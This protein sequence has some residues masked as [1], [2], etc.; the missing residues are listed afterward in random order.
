LCVRT[1]VNTN[2][3]GYNMTRL[4]KFILL[5][6]FIT[7]SSCEQKNSYSKVDVNVA[8][9]SNKI[10]PLVNFLDNPDSCKKALLF[11][12]SATTI[13]NG[14]FLCYYNKLMFLYSLKQYDKAVVTVNECI[15]LN[16]SGQDLYLT[17]G[18]LYERVGDTVS[19][20]R[21]FQ[22]S[23]TICNSV[24]DTMSN[25]NT[26]YDILVGNKAISLIMLG[27]EVE[28]D[29]IL[30]VL[31]DTQQDEEMKRMTLSL[32]TKTKKELIGQFTDDRY[33]H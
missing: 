22:K 17:G 27:H 28:A 15:R 30:K 5:F 24:L 19:A 13:D 21:Y 29:K 18:I 14:C 7:F 6:Y 12:D 20:K 1:F 9:L 23:L 3:S 25:K 33:S 11:L 16:P 10:I 26:D 4:C 8:R 32:M 2:V 31:Y